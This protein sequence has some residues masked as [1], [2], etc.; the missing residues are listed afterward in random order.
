MK[1][2]GIYLPQYHEIEENNRW[3]G[4]GY[5][6]W[7]AVKNAKPLF[8]GHNQPK[9]P[10]DNNYYDLAKN[11]VNV[12]KWQANLAKMYG[13]Y[14]FC[15]YHY[16]FAGKQLLEKPMETLRD[17][18]EISINYTICWANESWRRNWYGQEHHLLM[19]QT[20]GT[21]AVWEQHFEYLQT[22]FS[23][24]RYI[25]IDG[26]PLLHIYRS[27]DIQQLSEMLSMWNRLA[28][29]RGFPGLYVVSA[30]TAGKSD[31]RTGLFDA[32][33]NFEPGYTLKNDLP[34]PTY[35]GYLAQTAVH[36]FKDKYCKKSILEHCINTEKIYHRIEKRKLPS[37]V[38]PGT[39]PQW[40]NTPRRGIEGLCYTK[41]NPILFREHLKKLNAKYGNA[42]KFLYIN[43]WNEWGEGAYLEPDATWAY[44][45][46]K[47]VQEAGIGMD[48]GEN[49]E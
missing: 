45:Y 10:L 9:V 47:A 26:K 49:S 39:F 11:G 28:Q 1:A 19:E 6:E 31:N 35:I 32:Y 8:K 24:K 15:I 13:I 16:W 42:K 4:K 36:R 41:S 25:K 17:H 23:D 46:L 22:F 48:I 2:L 21:P 34:V 44:G 12:W 20:Y 30:L 27:S 5:T 33:Y 18:P 40:D 37:N 38:F 29:K 43:A 3:W 7:N 14:G